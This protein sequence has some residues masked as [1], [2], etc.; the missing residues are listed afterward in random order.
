MVEEADMDISSL[1]QGRQGYLWKLGG[2]QEKG[3]KWNKRWFVLRDNV[4]MYFTSPKEFTGFRDKP[5]GVVLL[6]ECNVRAREG[7]AGEHKLFHFSLVHNNGEETIVLGAEYEKEMLEWM[8]AVRTSRMCITDAE[9]AKQ[10]EG[11]RQAA[12]QME[13][14]GARERRSDTE[15]TLRKIDSSLE[16]VQTEHRQLEAEKEKAEKELKELMARFKLR[17]AL[18]HW[19]HRKLTLSFRSLISMV[20][21][22]RIDRAVQIKSVADGKLARM[23]HEFDQVHVARRKAEAAKKKSDEMLQRE[24]Q[25]KKECEAQMKEA[26]KMLKLE[27]A[28]SQ[29]A[30][31]QIGSLE[32]EGAAGIAVDTKEKEEL[33]QLHTRMMELRAEAE[34]MQLTLK[35][36]LPSK[37]KG[38][39]LPED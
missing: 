37:Q 17:K 32:G 11:E 6:E 31:A 14:E 10:S 24:L 12:A 26:Q 30:A 1:M 5:S 27:E 16:T 29:E 22:E 9:A 21:K 33:L 39:D 8:Q 35:V 19:R 25:L 18:L 13:L 20:F 28:R 34:E 15:D 3:S 38:V 2:G 36:Q 7:Q 23:Q 4:L